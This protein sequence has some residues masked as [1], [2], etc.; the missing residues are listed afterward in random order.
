MKRYPM[1]DPPEYVAW[2][3]DS[4][5]LEQYE[6]TLQRESQ[7]ARIVSQLNEEQLLG[8]YTGMVRFRLHDITLHRWV[9]QGILAKAWLGF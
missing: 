6:A 9:S 5:I 4:S 1:F 8:L 2:K 3:P 7:R